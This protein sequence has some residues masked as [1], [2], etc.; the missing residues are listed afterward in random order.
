[1][2]SRLI[3]NTGAEL[4]PE[5]RLRKSLLISNED[6]AIDIFIK[7]EEPNNTTVSTTDHDHIIGPRGIIGINSLIDGIKAIQGRWTIVAAS[8]TP[9]ISVFETEDVKR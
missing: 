2:P 4:I 1:M 6:T 7:Q 3:A 8:G 9:R 5:N